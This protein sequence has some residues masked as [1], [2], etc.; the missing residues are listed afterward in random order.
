M[1]RF[2]GAKFAAG[3]SAL[4]VLAAFVAVAIPAWPGAE[5]EAFAGSP[6]RAAT[7]VT[8]QLTGVAATSAR[9]AWAVGATATGAAGQTLI[10]RWNGASWTQ[11]PSPSVPTVTAP[12]SLAAIPRPIDPMQRARVS[13][14]SVSPS[15]GNRQTSRPDPARQE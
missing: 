7:A 10:L 5:G 8:G 2:R 15:A 4:A 9:A 1:R 12:T 6:S 14:P 3:G 11:V 13:L